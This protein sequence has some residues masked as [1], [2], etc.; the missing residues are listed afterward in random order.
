MFFCFR[1]NRG[2]PN[3]CFEMWQEIN[4]AQ[5]KMPPGISTWKLWGPG[6]RIHITKGPEFLSWKISNA[7]KQ[8][9]E[10]QNE[11]PCPPVSTINHWQKQ[12]SLICVAPT[13]PYPWIILQQTQIVSIC[14]YF[15]Q[16]VPLTHKDSWNHDTITTLKKLIN[17]L[18]LS[19]LVRIQFSNYLIAL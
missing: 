2:G 8:Q 16:Y 6:Y 1:Q 11:S 17:S 4:M 18:R 13:L 14:T 15:I 10:E 3:F 9:R 12:I 5:L 19:N 7:Y